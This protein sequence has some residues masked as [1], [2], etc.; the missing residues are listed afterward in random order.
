MQ[1]FYK[2][3]YL[4]L[5]LERLNCNFIFCVGQ[6]WIL[7]IKIFF[8]FDFEIIALQGSNFLLKVWI[9]ENKAFLT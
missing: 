6:Q 5:S 2:V 4:V 1:N 3:N 8:L 9:E 7:Y